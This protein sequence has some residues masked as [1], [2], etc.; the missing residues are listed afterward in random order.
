[1]NRTHKGRRDFIQSSSLAA[2]LPFMLPA[3]LAGTA[4]AAAD[5]SL[6]ISGL[7]VHIIKVNS[8]GNWVILEL[9]TNKGLTGFGEASQGVKTI[10]AAEQQLVRDEIKAF[11]EIAKNESPFAIVR[12]R[13][14]G[15]ELLKKK[16]S[17]LSHTA[18]SAIEQALWDIQGKALGAPVYSL[19]GGKIR[20][21]IKVYAN[22]NRATN[23]R[24]SNGRRP[25]YA[26]QKNAESA[27][28]AGFKAIKMAPF[29]EMRPLAGSSEQQIAD[30]INHAVNCLG[31]VRKTIGG[32]IDLLVDVHSHLDERLGVEVAKRVEPLNLFWFEEPVDPEHYIKET[33]V[34]S[35]STARATAGGESIFGAAGFYP[36]VKEKALDILMPDVKYCGGILELKNIAALANLEGIAIAPHNPGGPVSTAASV[37]VVATL[38]NFS[39]LEYAFGEVPWRAEL[40]QPAEAFIDGYI[41]VNG[42]PGL[43]VDMNPKTLAAHSV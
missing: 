41:T 9:A 33:K 3:G 22:I 43:G 12:Y 4:G 2:L 17:R 20:D 11:Y 6:K 42:R 14:K 19:L 21:K 27:L 23:D 1:M 24:D 18:F 36:L 25:A 37:Q 13:E 31:L 10:T 32:D 5:E 28:K 8:R 15:F 7:K 30:D 38:P 16:T 39:I 26:F 34:I 40:V 29:D 35:D